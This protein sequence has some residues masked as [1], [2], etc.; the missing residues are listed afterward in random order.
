MVSGITTSLRSFALSPHR[1]EPSFAEHRMLSERS[2]SNVM[3][4]RNE[5]N[6]SDWV[7]DQMETLHGAV[8]WEPN[9]DT[10]FAQLEQAERS[11]K[12]R[13]RIWLSAATAIA[14]ITVTLIV[15]P[16]SRIHLQ[17]MWQGVQ[18]A[19]AGRDTVS[20]FKLENIAGGYMTTQDLKGKVAV[21]DLWATW[22]EPCLREIPKYNELHE[23]FQGRDV[24]IVGIAVESPRNEIPSK[25]RDLNI[26]YTVLIGNDQAI[27]AFGGLLGFPTTFV[28]GKDGKIYKSYMGV[29]PNKH[30]NIRQDIESLLAEDYRKPD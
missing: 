21:V 22:C 3:E 30:E 26:D 14:A 27:A 17:K 1:L 9:A 10:A 12:A 28:L 24:A 2:T 4:H 16:S 13:R 15:I 8:D 7:D 23:A 18:T 6:T 29:L 25:V 20:N 11:H 19:Q 5:Q